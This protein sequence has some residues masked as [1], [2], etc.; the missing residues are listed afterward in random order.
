MLL[1]TDL[2]V[3]SHTTL[4]D[5]LFLFSCNSINIIIKKKTHITVTDKD[6]RAGCLSSEKSQSSLMFTRLV[7]INLFYS[8]L[9]VRALDL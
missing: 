5:S 3:Y 8:D 9:V 1:R 2:L 4:K 7:L 6:I